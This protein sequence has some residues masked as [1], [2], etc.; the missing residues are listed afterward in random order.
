MKVRKILHSHHAMAALS[1][2]GLRMSVAHKLSRVQISLGV[3]YE[4]F[5]KLRKQK[6]IDLKLDGK[7]NNDNG[8]LVFTDKDTSEQRE[9]HIKNYKILINELDEYKD[10]ESGFKVSPDNIILTDDLKKSDGTEIDVAPA[11]LSELNWLII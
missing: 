1:Q 10:Q 8:A 6:I 11:V 5:L 2:T 7:V 4:I 9:A 3:E